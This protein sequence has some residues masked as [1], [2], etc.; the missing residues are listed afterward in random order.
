MPH[1]DWYDYYVGEARRRTDKEAQRRA[2]HEAE[3]LREAQQR[4]ERQ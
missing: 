2:E 4:A 1:Q 3:R